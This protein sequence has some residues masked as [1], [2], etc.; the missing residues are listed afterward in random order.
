MHLDE[1]T[2]KITWKQLA[3]LCH[4]DPLLCCD[5]G[6]IELEMHQ[7]FIRLNVSVAYR[8]TKYVNRDDVSM[9]DK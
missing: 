5:R 3:Q 6:V 7:N 1:S 8:L 2:A 9:T 4:R